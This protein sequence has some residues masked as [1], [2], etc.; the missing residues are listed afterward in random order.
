MSRLV[1]STAGRSLR[2]PIAAVTA[3]SA[4]RRLSYE[5]EVDGAADPGEVVWAMVT[6]EEDQAEMADRPLL[7]VG[8]GDDG[9]VLALM[10]SSRE[11]RARDGNWMALGRGAWDGQRR[12]SYLRLDR[13]LELDEQGLRREGAVLARDQFDRVCAALRERYGWS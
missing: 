4:R 2:H 5:P 6:Y 10:L 12:R 3:R 11:R 9:Q 1:W 8:R 13:V 7:V